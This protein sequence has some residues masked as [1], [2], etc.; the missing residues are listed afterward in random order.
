MGDKPSKQQI[1]V[2]LACFALGQVTKISFSR[3]TGYVFGTVKDKGNFYA[4]NNE[5]RIEP[6]GIGIFIYIIEFLEAMGTQFGPKEESEEVVSFPIIN[7]N[8]Q[9]ALGEDEG[10]G[11]FFRITFTT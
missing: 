7:A 8:L 3:E 11:S 6:M 2:V 5:G 1:S 10:R 4:T 9:V